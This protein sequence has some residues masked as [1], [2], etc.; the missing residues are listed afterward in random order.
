MHS[1]SIRP[2][3]S[4][5]STCPRLRIRLLQTNGSCSVLPG[6]PVP[7]S[8]IVLQRQ[9]EPG[10]DHSCSIVNQVLLCNG[11][12]GVGVA[13]GGSGFSWVSARGC[14]SSPGVQSLASSS[15]SSSI[16]VALLERAGLLSV[17]RFPTIGSIPTKARLCGPFSGAALNC[18][19]TSWVKG[20]QLRTS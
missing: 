17:L 16:S 6:S 13:G 9:G 8:S 20:L 12:G 5:P 19:E 14:K 11:W 15:H 18:Y 2:S 7:Q 3:T 10:Q 4:L 1:Y